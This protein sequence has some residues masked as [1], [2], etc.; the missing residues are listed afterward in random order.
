MYT[1]TIASDTLDPNPNIERFEEYWEAE[2]FI[3]EEVE[4]RVNFLIEHSPY[5]IS[6]NEMDEMYETEYSLVRLEVVGE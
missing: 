3:H 1:V 2:E 5:S 6:E 4:R